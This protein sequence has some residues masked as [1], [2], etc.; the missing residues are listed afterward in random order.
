MEANK[1]DILQD[2][3]RMWPLMK[4]ILRLG[5]PIMVGQIGMVVT[6]FADTMMV[7]YYSTEALASASFVNN[8][9]NIAV[10][11]C[12]GFTFGVTPL[13]GMLFSQ[14]RQRDIGELMKCAVRLNIMFSLGVTAIMTLV[15]FNLERLG[16]P[17]ELLPLIRP[18]YLLYLSGLVSIS[19]FNAFA[20]WSY[21]INNTRQPMWIMLF[22]NVLNIAGNWL[23]IFGHF[24]CPEMGLTGAGISTFIARWFCPAAII[25]FFLFKKDFREYRQGFLQMKRSR[26]LSNRIKATSWPVALQ[27]SFEIGCF[28][29]A[30]VMT[31]WLGKVPLAAYQIT[32][33]V[34]GL[35]FMIYYSMAAA[36][37]VLVA[38]AV[39]RSDR[40]LMRRIAG[41]GYIVILIFAAVAS[42][43]FIVGGRP[44]MHMFSNDPAVLAVAVSLLF[45]LVL[46]QLGDATQITFANALRGT[47]HV[48]PMLWIAFFSYMVVGVPAAYFFGFTL[49]MGIYGIVLSFAIPL[50]MAGVLFLWQFLKVTREKTREN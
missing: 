36:T 3:Y 16:Q 20:Q 42:T 49:S 48:M 1:T 9:F 17:E 6:G 15:Y 28:T 33:I 13:V 8:I 12:L 30:A 27:M 39:G 5:L 46:Y 10:C 18:Y 43:I 22:S 40:R 24:G 26:M 19:L 44:L 34:G 11:A 31:G 7:G 21:A 29:V 38:N 47:S 4:K 23:L 37:S 14:N 50:F 35:G 25:S 2:N 41:A 32:M 45:P